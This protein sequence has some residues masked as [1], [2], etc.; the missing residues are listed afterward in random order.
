MDQGFASI[1]YPAVRE[2]FIANVK[3]S[4]PGN[5]VDADM[6]REHSSI[7]SISTDVV[8][9]FLKEA[10]ESRS[11]GVFIHFAIGVDIPIR[12]NSSPA[13][14]QERVEA[15]RKHVE[16]YNPV[17]KAYRKLLSAMWYFC[18]EHN[19]R[20]FRSIRSAFQDQEWEWDDTEEMLAATSELNRARQAMD[21]ARQALADSIKRCQDE[22]KR[23][24]RSVA[25]SQILPAL[26]DKYRSELEEMFASNKVGMV[27]T[28]VLM[29]E[30]A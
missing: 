7:A 2:W 10:C 4:P 5:R 13:K 20:V 27:K 12:K 9:A 26:P 15:A 17:P 19:E 18:N 22:R 28:S 6:I 29:I 11:G 23:Q 30:E 25:D 24:L 16:S 21:K 1:N 3:V 14:I 8:A